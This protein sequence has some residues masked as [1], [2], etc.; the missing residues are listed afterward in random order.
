MI[1]AGIALH[2]KLAGALEDR[3]R[4][5]LALAPGILA[6][7]FKAINDAFMMYAKEFAHDPSLAR[8]LASADRTAIDRIANE[9]RPTVPAGIPVIVG[10][11][12]K[13]WTGPLTDSASVAETRL[14]HM[15]VNVLG[16]SVAVHT[17]ALAPV[18]WS[19]RWV[20]AAGFAIPLTDDAARTLG[21]LTRSE[22][23]II[24]GASGRAVASTLDS[25]MTRGIVNAIA[26]RIRDASSSRE[27]FAD[28]ERVA[29]VTASLG[30]GGEAVFA[31]V[32]R[33]ELAIL[34]ELRRIA[35]F[36]ATGALILALVLG[37]LLANQV[38][39]P[40]RALAQSARAL[41]EGDF[42][43]PLPRSSL[44]EVSTV[45]E[46]FAAM[47]SALS[48]RL[49][50]LQQANRELEDRAVRLVS[51]QSDMLQRERLAASAQLVGHL[52]HEIRNPVA[53][54]R[55]LLEVIQRRV[56]HDAEAREYAA[57]AI[58][59]LLRMHELAERM[60]DL[61]RPRDPALQVAH[62]SQVARDVARLVSAGD[63][64]GN[65]AG[66]VVSVNGDANTAAAIA[67]DALKQ[68][69]LNL[70]QNAREAVQLA[71]PGGQPRI[72]ILVSSDAETVVVRV[73][74]NGPGITPEALPRI[75]DPFFTT[76]ESVQGVGLGL[77]VAE[78]IVR[79]AGGSLT[80]VNRVGGGAE[81]R[82]VLPAIG[83]GEPSTDARRGEAQ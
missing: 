7:W 49:A 21:S 14:G 27:A 30:S 28:G 73:A 46:T 42:A 20:G 9:Q 82:I 8:S 77:F 39:R 22:V 3:A 40:V 26:S 6:N 35:L 10:P 67:P 17:L 69:L 16:D 72:D 76:K 45:S 24:A 2:S 59:E 43:A 19:G 53:T 15:P 80:A 74:D 33:R 62:V 61:N 65:G 50:E 4:K 56:S 44:E 83:D 41:G 48:A 36:S 31:R 5:D 70:V 29:I 12:G 51:L 81:F 32:M 25:A 71:R 64:A 68:V 34:P 18:E 38:V 11:D 78:G 63:G 75:F 66:A 54:L 1:P 52:A 57:L 23:I 37:A 13:L 55:N 79:T 58:D 47:R 60:L